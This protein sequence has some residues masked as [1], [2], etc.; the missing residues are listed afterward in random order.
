M[1]YT[2]TIS[3]RRRDVW[4]KSPVRDRMIDL[5][6]AFIILPADRMFDI[7]YKMSFIA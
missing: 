4:R 6:G 5:V 1:D 3:G 2:T 7:V